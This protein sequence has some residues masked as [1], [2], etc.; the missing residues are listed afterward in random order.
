MGPVLAQ[1]VNIWRFDVGVTM[2]LFFWG[3]AFCEQDKYDIRP[4]RFF[5]GQA[6]VRKK[7]Q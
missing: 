3:K 1:F 6:S 4:G 5:T 2:G 7:S